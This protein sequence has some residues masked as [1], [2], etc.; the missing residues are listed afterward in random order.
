[1]AESRINEI[2]VDLAKGDFEVN[3]SSSQNGSWSLGCDITLEDV[4]ASI[5]EVRVNDITL[6]GSFSTEELSVDVNIARYNN[7]ELGIDFGIGAIGGGYV[8]DLNDVKA[9]LSEVNKSLS[10]VNEAIS[11]I[12]EE[13]VEIKSTINGI[14]NEVNDIGTELTTKASVESVTSIG[15]QVTEVQ[16]NLAEQTIKVGTLESEISTKA[17]AESVTSIARELEIANNAIAEQKIAVNDLSAEVSTKASAEQVTAIADGLTA[18][19]DA[20]AEQSLKVNSLSAEMLTKASA[21]SVTSLSGEL[22]ATNKAVA[23]QA[24]RVDSL[25][26]EISTKA[27]AESVTELD[28]GLKATS[29]SV[30][31]QAIKVSSLETEISS[32]ASTESVAIIG[33]QVVSVQNTVAEQII[34][35]DEL[36]A[37]IE[38]KVGNEE[39]NAATGQI[40]S[41]FTAVKQTT[42]R[43]ETTIREQNGE[44]TSIKENVSGLSVGIGKI[45]DDINSLR[46]ELDG[47]TDDGVLTPIE[48]EHL[49]EIYRG[50]AKEY[51]AAKGNAFNYK[52]WKYSVNGITEESGVNGGEGRYGKYVSFKDAYSHIA[53]IFGSGQWGFDKMDETTELATGQTTKIIKEYLDA[54]YTA[55]GE[56]TEVF[57]S[58]TAAIEDVQKKAEA[59]LAELTGI[60]SP[61]EM[62]T[63]VG[64]GV[65]LSTIIATRDAEGKITA[66]MNASDAH[67]DASPENHGRVVF[68]GGARNINDFNEAAYVVYEDGHVKMKSAE[69]SEYASVSALQMGLETKASVNDF[70]DLLGVV[71]NIIQSIAKMWRIEDGNIV[72]DYNIVTSKEISAGGAGEEGDF[73]AQGT[74][75]G[76][77]VKEGEVISPDNNGTVDLSEVLKDVVDGIDLSDYAT[78]TDVD[79]RI[80]EIVDGAPEAL[81]TLKEI[82]QAL[83]END[84]EIGAITAT[85]AKKADKTEVTAVDEKYAGEVSGLKTRVTKNEGDIA[86]IK[87]DIVDIEAKD[88]EQDDTLRTLESGLRTLQDWH[89]KVGNRFSL[90]DDGETINVDLN[91]ATSKELSAGG[92]GSEMEG[93]GVGGSLDSLSDVRIGTMPS[94]EY[95]RASQRIG[96]ENGYWVNKTTMYRHN[97]NTASA[98]WSI[99]HNL[100]KM[101]N[102]KVVDSTGELVFGTVKYDTNDLLNKLT[103]TFGGSFA[104]TAYLD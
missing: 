15:E 59:T 32:K 51:D 53:T 87:E 18:V 3:A 68:V 72:T 75:T 23:E 43:I 65:V 88:E 9:G 64:K 52:I 1:M 38:N 16:S 17:S 62:Y 60:L 73:N 47:I 33:G 86:G 96:Y 78:K 21:E 103:I 2:G 12:N 34:R 30:A 31:E 50:I 42:D 14:Q 100:G 7:T 81:D 27:S 102:V 46:G 39:F 36:E 83:S 93:E 22:Q 84:S 11:G 20:V 74:V 76:I 101:P 80:N 58:I 19:N 13:A 69:I 63:Q 85:L 89:A 91:F 99:T 44:I 40:A 90:S 8:D 6:S 55:Y 57:S 28:A 56:L 37:S 48:K 94:D 82:A 25:S 70:N 49:Y 77:K 97:Q 92:A 61:E 10:D 54:Y 24:I 5:Q 71:N 35:T 98:V 66:G 26:T 41:E 29:S 67:K 104:G 95:Q 45:E 79:N 4:D